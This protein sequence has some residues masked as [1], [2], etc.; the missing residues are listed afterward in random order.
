MTKSTV[1]VT[2]ANGFVGQ[3]VC[4]RFSE[5]RWHVR[6]AVRTSDSRGGDAHHSTVETGDIS[7]STDW[8]EALSGV[9]VVVHLAARVHVMRDAERSP[10]DAFRRVNVAGTERLALQARGAGV[11]RLIFVSTIKVNG[12]GTE[13]GRA[14]RAEDP[15]NPS[16]A[17]AQSKFEAEQAL[18]ASAG[19]METVILRPPLVYGPRVR[20]NFLT[21]MRWVYRGVPLP[22]GAIKNRRSLLFVSNLA[23]LA[24]R[25][26]IHPNAANQTFLVADGEDLSTPDLVRR[27]ARSLAV[28]AR[29]VP[30]PVGMLRAAGRM[31]GRTAEVDRL[32]GSL[33]IDTTRTCSRLEWTAPW[34][35]DEALEQTARH[36]LA[37]NTS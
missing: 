26:S 16:G 7:G 2:G 31:L 29:L 8:A 24:L 10:L 18:V 12:E 3:A 32:C 27:L 13:Q 21:M 5:D 9:D 1:L 15:T 14:F 17:Y 11:K 23:D 33:R 22:L 36:F 35:V 28:A 34:S 30:V 20:A 19:R 4:A 6:R 25:S 37:T